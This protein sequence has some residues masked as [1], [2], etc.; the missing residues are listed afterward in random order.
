MQGMYVPQVRICYELYSDIPER[1][2]QLTVQTETSHANKL[3]VLFANL[4]ILQ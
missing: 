3:S 4:V 1:A 2:F